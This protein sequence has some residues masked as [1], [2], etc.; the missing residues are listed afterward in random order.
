M[1]CLAPV[2][3]GVEPDRGPGFKV[4][5]RPAGSFQLLDGDRVIFVGDTLVER[6]QNS[7]YLETFLTARYPSHNVVYR[8][9]GWSGDTVFGDARAGFGTAAEGF[10]Q[11]RQQVFSLKPTVIF[12]AY[13]GNMSFAGPAGLEHFTRGFKTLL[14]MLAT[15]KAELIL[16]S[17]IRHE[18]L[19][20]PLPDPTSHN[21]SLELYSEAIHKL[22]L[23]RGCRFIDLFRALTPPEGTAGREFLTEN[24]IHLSPY[25]YWLA[26]QAME[27]SLELSPAPWELTVSA[28]DR[29]VTAKG[30]KASDLAAEN[31]SLKFTLTDDRLPEPVLPGKHDFGRVVRIRGLPAGPYCLKIDG[32]II[33]MAKAEEWSKGRLVRSGPEFDQVECLRETIIAK[34]RLYFYRWRPQNETYL[35]GFRKHEQGQNAREIPLFDPLVSEQETRIATLRKPAPHVYEVVRAR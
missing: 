27:R 11:L 35:F 5:P 19:G 17:P 30:A 6:A 12:V 4:P 29:R 20:R 25:G 24:G 18:D 34:N 15:T 21:R 23:E 14:D 10:A 13:G 9:L 32:A 26:A 16:V 33:E 2:A 1:G 7:G 8:N 22:A 28:P 31:G 3:R